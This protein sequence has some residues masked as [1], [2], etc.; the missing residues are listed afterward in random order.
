[1]SE[2]TTS[3]PGKINPP[4]GTVATADAAADGAALGASEAAVEAA[5]DGAAVGD[6]VAGALEPDGL[7][8]DDEHAASVMATVTTTT[9]RRLPGSI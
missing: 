3:L 4:A 2:Q 7:A 9:A 1:M 5:A 8:L 6:S